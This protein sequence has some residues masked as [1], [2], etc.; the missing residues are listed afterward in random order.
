MREQWMSDAY[1]EVSKRFDLTHKQRTALDTSPLYMPI[2]EAA[3]AG[4]WG[5]VTHLLR[6]AG[7]SAMA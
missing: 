2:L 3:R 1:A 6:S 4:N 7:I 5:E